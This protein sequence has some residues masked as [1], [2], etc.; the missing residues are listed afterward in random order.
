MIDSIVK[1]KKKKAVG[2]FINSVEYTTSILVNMPAAVVRV[3]MAC[4]CDQ[5]STK[6]MVLAVFWKE[7]ALYTSLRLQKACTLDI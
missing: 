2:G 7:S 5:S 4:T 1:E 6:S 3:G